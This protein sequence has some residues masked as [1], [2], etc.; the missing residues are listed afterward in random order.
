MSTGNDNN[1]RPL[2]TLLSTPNKAKKFG[3]RST[4]ASTADTPGSTNG[5]KQSVK[6]TVIKPTTNSD[7]ALAGLVI[8]PMGFMADKHLSDILG[9]KASE[10]PKTADFLN[11]TGAIPYIVYNQDEQGNRV[12][13]MSRKK[14]YPV[15]SAFIPLEDTDVANEA[16]VKKTVAKLGY[17]IFKY[18]EDDL[19]HYYS[20]KND[21]GAS[22]M[23]VIL[24]WDR[25]VRTVSTFS[26]AV[27]DRMDDDNRKALY[28]TLHLSLKS[29]DSTLK[30]W[31]SLDGDNNIYSIFKPGKVDFHWFNKRNL[32]FECLN[33]ADKAAYKTWC[34]EKELAAQAARQPTAENFN[35]KNYFGCSSD[36]E[37]ES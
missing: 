25:D 34:E 31:L 23:P 32:P 7:S 20:N 14:F 37:N 6:V 12:V 1:K 10:N 24:D 17:G 36:S 15:A 28:M 21:N 3:K 35:A 13:K 33:N 16:T 26:E 11:K 2:V 8:S 9:K 22:E 4:P 27:T 5:T 18:L 30:E 29:A 19:P